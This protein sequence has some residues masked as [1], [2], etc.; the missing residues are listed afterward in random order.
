M[1]NEFDITGKLDNTMATRGKNRLVLIL[2]GEDEF[3][4]LDKTSLEVV[5]TL[6]GIKDNKVY[7][8]TY[9]NWTTD[10]LKM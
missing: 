8:L 5:S 4:R 9:I 10:K 2:L 7:K 3:N 1:G 6:T